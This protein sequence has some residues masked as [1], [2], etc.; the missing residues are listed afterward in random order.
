MEAQRHIV[1]QFIDFSNRHNNILYGKDS[2][3]SWEKQLALC[4]NEYC[5]KIIMYDETRLRDNN[6]KIDRRFYGRCYCGPSKIQHLYCE[7]HDDVLKDCEEC[8]ETYCPE[9]KCDCT[10]Q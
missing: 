4:S 10:K 9:H 8:S 1:K 3:V 6:R 2:S 5:S 7:E